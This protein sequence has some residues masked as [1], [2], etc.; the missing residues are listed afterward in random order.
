MAW[1]VWIGI[2]IALGLIEIFTLDLVFLMLSGGAA[3]AA[4]AAGLRLPWWG[5]VLVFCAV[6]VLML[7]AVRP[8]ALARLKTEGRAPVVTG[9]A[10]LVGQRGQALTNVSATNGRVKIEGEVWSARTTD[11]SAP[12]PAGATVEVTAIDGATAVVTLR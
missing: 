1:I 6:S 8:W 3:A 4:V 9:A 2:A 5:C 10:A 11:S 12:V 7:A